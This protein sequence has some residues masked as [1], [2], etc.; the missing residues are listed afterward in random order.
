MWAKVHRLPLWPTEDRDDRG[1]MWERNGPCLSGIPCACR[2]D[3][4]MH[5]DVGALFMLMKLARTP[6]DARVV[7]GTV[8]VV[9]GCRARHMDTEAFPDRMC[10]LFVKV[11]GH[12]PR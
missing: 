12:P 11:R 2:H 1:C 8:Q 7:L 5:A 4:P 9:R 3:D 6:E 10:A